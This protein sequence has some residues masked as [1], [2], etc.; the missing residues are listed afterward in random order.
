MKLIQVADLH[1]HEGHYRWLAAEMRRTRYDVLVIAGDLLNL[2]QYPKLRDQ[3]RLIRTIVR[4]LPP[5]LVVLICSG[6][7]DMLV[8]D[9]FL[10]EAQ[11]LRELQRPNVYI[12]GDSVTLASR[13][14]ECVAWGRVPEGEP[15][16]IICHSPPAGACTAL[17]PNGDFG[18]PEITNHLLLH[19]AANGIVLCGHVHRAASWHDLR[20]RFRSLNPCQNLKALEPSNIVIDVEAGT[21]TR[22]A[23]TVSLGWSAPF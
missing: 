15:D 5:E 12:D 16:F 19:T 20:S 21:A 14:F 1:G 18:D 9:R 13:T 3:L 22:K 23:Q 10:E 8:G 7:H 6:N 17:S 2:A 11:W 4:N